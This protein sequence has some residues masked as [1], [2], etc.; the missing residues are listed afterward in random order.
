MYIEST[1]INI[2]RGATMHKYDMYELFNEAIDELKGAKDYMSK[3]LYFKYEDDKDN[4]RKFYELASDECNH[5]DVL[6]TMAHDIK[7]KH[8][9]NMTTD[10]VYYLNMLKDDYS[11][12]LLRTKTAMLMFEDKV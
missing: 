7:E 12:H 9:D 10:E 11:K 4:A 3:A 1:L 5:A 6:H 8:K 2:L